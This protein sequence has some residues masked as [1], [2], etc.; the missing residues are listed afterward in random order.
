MLLYGDKQTVIYYTRLRL[1]MAYN[2]TYRSRNHDNLVEFLNRMNAR[3]FAVTR[4][5]EAPTGTDMT[6]NDDVASWATN[7]EGCNVRLDNTETGNRQTIAVMYTGDDWC[8]VVPIVDWSYTIHAEDVVN[9]VINEIR[10][11]I[12]GDD[13]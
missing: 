12:L 10:E 11:E 1:I 5:T 13:A 6:N 3:G 7:Y 8:D 4:M 2:H 9:Q